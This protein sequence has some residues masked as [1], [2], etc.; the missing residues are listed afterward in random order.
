MQEKPLISII[1]ATFGH[2]EYIKYALDSILMQETEY[3]FEV[4]IG[5]DCSPDNTRAILKEYEKK[6]PYIFTIFYREENIGR[7]ANSQDLLWRAKGKY[8]ALLEGDDYW[9]SSN[10]LQKLA[11]FLENNLEYMGVANKTMVVDENNNQIKDVI[12]PECNKKDF[13]LREYRHGFLPGQTAATMIR[14]VYRDK[15]FDLSIEKKRPNMLPGDRITSFLW[16]SNGKYRCIND[17]MSAYRYVISSG[18]S[19]SANSHKS[20]DEYLENQLVFNKQLLEHIRSNYSKEAIATISSL[21]LFYLLFAAIKYNNYSLKTFF[22]AFFKEKHKLLTSAYLICS[23]TR[24]LF[25]KYNSK[26]NR[27]I[28]W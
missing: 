3:S 25:R 10:R 19:F 23:I 13:T 11:Y 20:I 22:I 15:Q 14:N 12:Y 24:S 8:L 26:A 2:E 17:V 16:V 1:M 18:S 21:Y 28:G 7:K 27:Y 4:L 5:E 6:H 9:I